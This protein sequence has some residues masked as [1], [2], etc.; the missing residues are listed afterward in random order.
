MGSSPHTRGARFVRRDD[1]L[2]L[3][4]IPAYAGSTVIH[5]LSGN[6]RKDHPRIRGE[7]ALSSI[8]ADDVRGSSP[9]TR[10]APR[11]ISFPWRGSGI[12]PAYAGS[13]R[14][15]HRHRRPELHHPRIRGE[16]TSRP[17]A[18]RTPSG[19]SPHT[20][21]ARSGPTGRAAAPG[22]I[23]AYAGSTSPSKSATASRSGSSPHTRGALGRHRRK[24]PPRRIIP[25]YAGSTG[26][27]RRPRIPDTDHPRIRGEHTT[28][29]GRLRPP[30]GSSPHTRGAQRRES[31]DVQGGGIIPAY[32]GSTTMTSANITIQGG[33]SPHT[34]GALCFDGGD[35][36]D[37]GIIPA[38]AG[39]TSD[40]RRTMLFG[41][42]HPRI[43]GEHTPGCLDMHVR[44]GSSPHTRG[45]RT[46][47]ADT[48][49]EDGIIPAY[50]GS[51][52]W[53]HGCRLRGGD[54]PRIRGEHHFGH[55]VYTVGIGSSPHTRGALFLPAVRP[56]D[57]GIIPAYAG[58]T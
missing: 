58:S 31:L 49:E 39:S 34:R 12:I 54:H 14:R 55:L 33:S 28:R 42:D 20:R 53:C 2:R 37:G 8:L 29:A 43:R 10:G 21:G 7:H 9:H 36:R 40:W 30:R 57:V 25:A 56:S 52:C 41:R 18:T 44:K 23:P 6:R 15:V 27:R 17:R 1:I 19:S 50:A 3:R 35:G 4:I 32:A 24:R 45:A 16:H 47:M 5:L 22:I 51:T 48:P 46:C 11:S 13:T 26:R 38:Y